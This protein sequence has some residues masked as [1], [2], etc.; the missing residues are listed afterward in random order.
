[1]N[2]RQFNTRLAALGLAPLAPLPTAAP[3]AA[4]PLSGT[5]AMHYNWAA[6]YAR[7]HDACSPERLARAFRLAPETA[8]EIF[9]KLQADGVITAPGLSGLAR[10]VNPINWDLQFS[11]SA[12]QTTRAALSRRL[13]R[14]LDP[15]ETGTPEPD[16]RAASEA[17]TK[18]ESARSPE[19]PSTGSAE[20][21]PAGNR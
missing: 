11:P 10:A 21:P 16:E 7:V 3:A 19:A 2:R 1:M 20:C 8:T 6:R 17:A 4:A 14:V 18:T 13:R 12:A 5:A 9:V 15:S